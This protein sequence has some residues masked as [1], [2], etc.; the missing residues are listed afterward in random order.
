MRVLF[1]GERMIANRTYR[2]EYMGVFQEMLG[3]A[4]R[5]HFD[6]MALPSYTHP[7]PAMS[8][9]FWK[10]LDTALQLAGDVSGRS[11]LDFGCGGCTTFRHLHAKGCRISGVDPYALDL[12][13]EVCRRLGIEASL[14]R[15]LEEMTPRIYDVIFALDVLEHVE[16]LD[17]CLKDLLRFAGPGTAIIVSGPTENVFYKFGR[18]LAGFSGHYHLTNIYDIESRFRQTG[19]VR[20]AARTLYPP[21][22][23]FRVSRWSAGR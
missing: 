18:W 1:E 22:P 23:L 12:A 3:G 5:G 8:W 14:Y 7:N 20:D 2:R 4:P 16:D 21:V 19:L 15:S 17:G 6:E 9:L 13:S 11:I 10:R